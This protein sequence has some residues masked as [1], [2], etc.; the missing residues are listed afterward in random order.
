MSKIIAMQTT[1]KRVYVQY[2][3]GPNQPIYNFTYSTDLFRRDTPTPGP[4]RDVLPPP[5]PYTLDTSHIESLTESERK[6][7]ERCQPTNHLNEFTA[8]QFVVRVSCAKKLCAWLLDK[9]STLT[10]EYKQIYD[11]YPM[12]AFY[13][14]GSIPKRSFGVA[15]NSDDKSVLHTVSASLMFDNVTLGGTPTDKLTRVDQWDDKTI[16]F[17]KATRNPGCYLDPLGFWVFLLENSE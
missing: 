15:I 8:E 9:D 17:I 5:S 1:P 3:P 4:V 12:W 7:I 2:Q 16:A 10:Q 14:D 11:A 6:E 13:L